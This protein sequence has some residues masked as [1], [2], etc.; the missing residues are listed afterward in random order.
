[1]KNKPPY[2]LASVD[3]ALLLLQMLRDHGSLRVSEAAEELDIARSTA[4]RLLSMLV[5]R[6]F[7]MQDDRRTYVPGPA[8]TAS[9]VV[10]RPLQQLRRCLGPHLDALCERVQETVNLIVRVGVQARFLASVE[11]TQVLHVGDRQGTILP[12]HLTSGGKALLAELEPEQ[13]ERLYASSAAGPKEPGETGTGDPHLSEQAWAELLRELEAVRTRGYS[14]NIEGTEA[15]VSA[16][17]ACVYGASGEALGAVSISA[18]SARFDKQRIP[19]FVRELRA[20]AA[21]A[22]GDLRSLSQL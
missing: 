22:Q 21:D 20:M 6:D 12:A 8:L 13:L 5:Y 9:Q 11:S 16:V 1:M 10:G 3:N 7:A 17:G 18:P 14:L 4:H 15:G 19:G 2:A